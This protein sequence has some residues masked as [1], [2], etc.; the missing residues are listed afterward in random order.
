MTHR[1][2]AWI[3]SKD[4]DFRSEALIDRFWVVV[5]LVAAMVLYGTSLGKL[6]LRDWD[7]GIVA[8]V[9]RELWR[10]PFESLRWL[11]PTIQG[12][13]YLNKP[14][15]MHWLIA[16]VYAIGGVNE[17][18][19]RL[20]GASLTALSVP[21]LYGIGR[22][23]FPRRTQ[24]LFSAM[25]YLT[26]L[27]VVR[28]G[29][30]AMLDGAVLCFFVGMLFCLL[31]SRR[32]LRWGLGAGI[33]FG[34]IC[35]TKGIL[36][37][38]LGA[39]AL[40]FVVLDTPRLLT[41][42]YLWIGIAIGSA[43]AIAWYSCQWLRY[44]QELLANLQEQSF[45]RIWKTVENHGGAPWYYILEILK[46][47]LPWLLFLPQ[48]FRLAWE[49]R[50]LSW[51][52]LVLVWSSIYLTV[53]SAM[54]TKLP[55]YVLPIYPALA[56]IAGAQ[57]AEVWQESTFSG[58]Y[59]AK[60]KIFFRVL[61][62][63]F[64]LLALVG[65]GGCIFLSLS[66]PFDPNLQ[67]MLASVAFMMTV[68]AVLAIKRDSQFV[69]VLIWGSYVSLLLLVNSEHWVWELAEAY[70][71]KPVAAIVQAKTPA[72]Q[73]IYTS[74]PYYRP[75]LDFYSDRQIIPAEPAKLQQYWQTANPY[76]LIGKPA[77]ANLPLK[78]VKVLG[79]AEN[80]VLITRKFALQTQQ[81]LNLGAI[82]K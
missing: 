30:L 62:G 44:S 53:I 18:T 2:F 42:T 22:E 3:R 50:T 68:A 55:W 48:G 21:L 25:V 58:A 29:R 61:I 17:W 28:N 14:P 71:V 26:L 82:K 64:I 74:Y 13:P 52:K 6:P 27:P 39:I 77:L 10:T 1:N 9:A 46:Y 73:V 70:P 60:S 19:T 33:G 76:V 47:S 81:V 57:L 41:S 7:E 16:G 35:L 12:A 67:I 79:E 5:L 45:N 43:P 72:K 59:R 20:P 65:W 56:L 69:A 80:W 8:Q 40:L 38:L 34:L 63:I 78:Q 51:A 75:S 23:I 54:G 31:R 66:T 37:L 15:L 4:W 49:N 11:Y 24:A 32:D 36:G